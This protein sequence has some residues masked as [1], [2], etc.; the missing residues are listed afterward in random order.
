MADVYDFFSR[1]NFVEVLKQSF[2]K[3]DLVLENPG[4]Y[5]GVLTKEQTKSHREVLNLIHAKR[6]QIEFLTEEFN[7]IWEVY[8][9]MVLNTLAFLR[10]KAIGV[11]YDNRKHELIVDIK[12]HC[13]VRNRDRD[14]QPDYA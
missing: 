2:P 5:V 1:K 8:D 13:W 3:N 7:Q 12:G 14:N 10:V 11:E 4:K 6:A 9:Q